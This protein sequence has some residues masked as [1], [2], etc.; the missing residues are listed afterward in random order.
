[1]RIAN[2]ALVH[3]EVSVMTHQLHMEETALSAVK[4]AGEVVGNI[5]GAFISGLVGKK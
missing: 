1:M 3:G 2:R 5:A 4:D